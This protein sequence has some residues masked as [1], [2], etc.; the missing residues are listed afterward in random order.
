MYFV[1]CMCVGCNQVRLNQT[2]FI[3]NSYPKR[4]SH[5]V[6]QVWYLC[7]FIA[8]WRLFCKPLHKKC[9]KNVKKKIKTPKQCIFKNRL[10]EIQMMV[11]MDVRLCNN[12]QFAGIQDRRLLPNF[13]ISFQIWILSLKN[14][15]FITAVCICLF[16]FNEF[17]SN[18]F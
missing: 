4:N 14:M 2:Q 13:N 17:V 8:F 12:W 16:V 9:S 10:K 7:S 11:C 6:L 18:C 15:I 5:R 1:G 3:Y